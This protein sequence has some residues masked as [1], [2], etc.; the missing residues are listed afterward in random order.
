M[1]RH[2]SERNGYDDFD[3]SRECL[4]AVINKRISVEGYFVKMGRYYDR[5]A[6]AWLSRA[7]FKDVRYNGHLI[8]HIGLTNGDKLDRHNPKPGE[9]VHFSAR[10]KS[11][12]KRLPQVNSHALM[13]K[14]TYTLELPEQFVFPERE[15][16]DSRAGVGSLVRSTAANDNPHPPIQGEPRLDVNLITK[17]KAFRKECECPWEDIKLAIKLLED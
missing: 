17:V 8:E 10:V 1:I 12:N 4:A 7:V 16:M 11:Y 13:I 6:Q 9:L 15:E 3:Q 14:T 2:T 5:H